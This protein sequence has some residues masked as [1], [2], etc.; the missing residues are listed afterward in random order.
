MPAIEGSDASFFHLVGVD[1]IMLTKLLFKEGVEG[2][3]I[4]RM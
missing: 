4:I 1:G 2:Q 3:W